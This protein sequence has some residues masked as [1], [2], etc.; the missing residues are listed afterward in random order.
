MTFG[1]MAVDSFESAEVEYLSLSSRQV[2]CRQSWWQMWYFWQCECSRTIMMNVW[3]GCLDDFFDIWNVSYGCHL[4][5]MSAGFLLCS[6]Y[7]LAALPHLQKVVD[8]GHCVQF[9]FLRL[10]LQF[11]V[12]FS[13]CVIKCCEIACQYSVIGSSKLPY[14]D[15]SRSLLPLIVDCLQPITSRPGEKL[16]S[17]LTPCGII[18][19]MSSA[20]LERLAYFERVSSRC[21]HQAVISANQTVLLISMGSEW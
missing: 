13:F 17:T 8:L 19:N 7:V 18:Q 16:A 9:S 6:M 2:L 1:R 21:C 10:C 20:T 5:V 4:H 15:F 12:V 11:H 14:Y 3:P